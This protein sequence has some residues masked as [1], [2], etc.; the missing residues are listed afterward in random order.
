MGTVLNLILVAAMIFGLV[1]ALVYVVRTRNRFSRLLKQAQEW[2]AQFQEQV[3]NRREV[4]KLTIVMGAKAIAHAEHTTRVGARHRATGN[5]KRGSSVYVDGAG[6]P[7]AHAVDVLKSAMREGIRGRQDE[8]QVRR[9][10]IAAIRDYN[11]E[12]ACLPHG[13][14]VRRFLGVRPWVYPA[15]RKRT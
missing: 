12:L 11:E 1:R 7:A 5:S 13:W 2:H 9:A 15:V 4:D 10:Y 14:V 8:N 3:R 6:W